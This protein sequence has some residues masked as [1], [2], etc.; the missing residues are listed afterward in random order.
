MVTAL[1]SSEKWRLGWG[2]DHTN[3]LWQHPPTSPVVIVW[4][5]ILILM[6]IVL[7][8]LIQIVHKRLHV[9][10]IYNWKLQTM[11][12][13]N[14]LEEAWLL[15]LASHPHHSPPL[16]LHSNLNPNNLF[17]TPCQIYQLNY[18]FNTSPITPFNIWPRLWDQPLQLQLAHQSQK[19]R[20]YLP[21][22]W[23]IIDYH[24]LNPPPKLSLIY[25]GEERTPYTPIL[26]T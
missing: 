4:K 24:S 7:W 5:L 8:Y 20:D 15:V 26:L 21:N 13:Y 19:S 11:L 10:H 25:I 17:C 2:I 12:H 1:G 3:H 16:A 6:S 22:I 23:I 18:A 9:H 14:M